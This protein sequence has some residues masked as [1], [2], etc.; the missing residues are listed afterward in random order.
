M[1]L[2]DQA[3]FQNLLT[4]VGANAREN[5]INV[6]Y[7]NY[8]GQTAVRTIIPIRFLFGSTEYHQDEQWLIEVWDLQKNALRTYALKDISQ[9]FNG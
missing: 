6:R 8:R 7:T 4:R 9:W 2:P 3:I 5:P 1:E